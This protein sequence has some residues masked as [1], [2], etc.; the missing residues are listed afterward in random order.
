MRAEGNFQRIGARSNAH[1]GSA[2]EEVA[3]LSFEK[4]GIVLVPDF[5][6]LIGASRAKKHRRFD[7]GSADPPVLVECKSHRWT[8]GSNVPSA[9]I[10]VWNEAMLYFALAP[11]NFRKILFV[12]KDHSPSRGCT[13]AEYYVRNYG[14]LIPDGVEIEEYD[15]GA[16]TVARVYPPT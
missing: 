15:E 3:R 13:L 1:V 6:V 12:L 7:L 2:F 11:A 14:H 4:R 5:P 10:T 8:V 9:K 16:G